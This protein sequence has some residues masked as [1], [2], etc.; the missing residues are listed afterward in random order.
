LLCPPPWDL[1]NAGVE[2]ASLLSPEL[3]GRFFTTS[4]TWEAHLSVL[5]IK[6]INLNNQILYYKSMLGAKKK[7]R[8]LDLNTKEKKKW[9]D[10]GRQF[11]K[12]Y[13]LAS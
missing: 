12:K 10:T 13:L 5:Y 2:P 6:N 3:A 1:P 11:Q 7:Q 8:Y 4:A 9:S